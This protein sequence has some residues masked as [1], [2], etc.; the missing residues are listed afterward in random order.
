M[1]YEKGYDVPKNYILAHMWFSLAAVQDPAYE[2]VVKK[3]LDT[4][5]QH[6]APSQI[7]EAQKLA[8]EWKPK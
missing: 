5:T 6:M 2:R 3:N 7:A 8:R 1:F 4:I